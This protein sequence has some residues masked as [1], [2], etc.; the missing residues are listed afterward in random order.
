MRA[1]VSLHHVSLRGQAG[2]HCEFAQMT[3]PP[4]AGTTQMCPQEPQLLGSVVVSMPH[5]P[6]HVVVVAGTHPPLQLVKPA[7]HWSGPHIPPLQMLVPF[8]RAPEHACVQV[9]QCCCDVFR[10]AQLLVLLQ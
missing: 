5:V 3:L 6:L 7:S 8:T 2:T 10:F 1:Q 9:P 4:L